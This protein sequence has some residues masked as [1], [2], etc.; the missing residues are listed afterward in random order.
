[1]KEAEG[2]GV[3]PG[4]ETSPAPVAMGVRSVALTMAEQQRV[5]A[6]QQLAR[7]PDRSTY[8]TLQQE[9]AQQLQMSVRNVQ[10]LVR[11]WERDGVAGVI[12]QGRS[13]R[14]QRRLDEDWTNYIVETYRAGNRG[15]RRMSRAQV[16]VRVVARAI[17]LGHSNPPSRASVYRILQSE[18][19]RQE[20]RSR[21]R[22][23]GWQGETLILKTREGLEVEVTE[24]NQVWQCDSCGKLR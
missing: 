20:Q 16:A 12:R 1:M 6:M 22:S 10:H 2:A 9:I 18:I 17:E 23:I 19:D 7:A 8:V 4:R 15:G 3:E 14:G 5:K 11:A 13:D 21:V 24:S